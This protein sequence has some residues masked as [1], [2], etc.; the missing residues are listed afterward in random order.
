MSRIREMREELNWYY[1]RLEIEQLQGDDP[2]RERV[3]KLRRQ[4]LAHENELLRA[5][6]EIPASQQL[7]YTFPPV[8]V[9][10]IRA[11]LPPDSA[12]AEYFSVKDQF[13]AAILT[14]QSL[15]IVPLAPVSRVTNLI[16][17]LDFQIGK[18]HLGGEYIREFEKPLFQAIQVHLRSL[19]IELF[20]PLRRRLSC[21]HLVIVP[22]GPLHYVPFHALF[23][24]E[25]YLIDSYTI[26]YAPSATVF[27]VCQERAVSATG[28][29]LVMGVPDIQ[30]PFIREE[31]MAVAQTL[32]GA[33]VFLGRDAT[34]AIFRKKGSQ[35]RTIHLATHGTFRQDNPMFSGI[36]LGETYL[37]LYD[38]Y[39]LKVECELFT[40]SGCATGVNVVASGDE[41]LGLTRGL[42]YAG[43]RSVL[44]TLW[45]VHDLSTAEFMTAFYR[46]WKDNSSKPMAL[47]AAML[48]LRD[49]YPHPYYWAPF[50]LT[51]RISPV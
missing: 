13:V 9:D 24:S 32:P 38:L 1:R 4:V 51:G 26:S 15:E 20:S 22:H 35:S 17:M 10:R 45:N 39:Q 46:H 7:A 8:S 48:E 36:R 6:R 5:F 27:A 2:A 18:F 40:L 34:D 33:Q 47:R 43:A 23:D 49:R 25:R 30:A 19:Y 12:L 16:R 50:A 37:S 3:E 28:P 41:L 29:P 42:L 21:R 31:V 11:A 14:R 44:L